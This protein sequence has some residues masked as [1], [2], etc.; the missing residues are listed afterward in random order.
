[1]NDTE[2]RLT[3]IESALFTARGK[4]GLVEDMETMK[5]DIK[6]WVGSDRE[7][8][9]FFLLMQKSMLNNKK[10]R[11][12]QIASV[13]GRISLGVAMVTLLLRVFGKI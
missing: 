3:A 11:L 9:C 13:V 10:Y 4:K 7:R 12:Q 5:A 8:T 6:R 2:A 1:M